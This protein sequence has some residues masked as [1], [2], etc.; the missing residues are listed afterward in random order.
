MRGV[1]SF[2]LAYSAPLERVRRP[3][4]LVALERRRGPHVVDVLAVRP[5]TLP[6][7]R[8]SASGTLP[9]VAGRHLRELR[10]RLPGL[11]MA[12]RPEGRARL[13]DG[14][15]YELNFRFRAA[16]RTQYGRDVLVVPEGV[17]QGVLIELR[18]TRRPGPDE[19]V[20]ARG[21]LRL[22][23]RSFAFETDAGA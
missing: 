13:T 15:S 12:N 7:Y 21:A 17:R 4:T 23:L 5:L 11:A 14:P 20:G 9:I 1:R 22:P 6:A 2:S 18:S 16:G 19:S 3:G 8:G 10:R